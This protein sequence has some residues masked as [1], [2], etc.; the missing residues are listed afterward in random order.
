M[1]ADLFRLML[2]IAG[3]LLVLGIYFFGRNKGAKP[4][5]RIDHKAI[6]S[7]SEK[8]QERK[9][10]SLR[11]QA[12]PLESSSAVVEKKGATPAAHAPWPN[13]LLAHETTPAH[14]TAATQI[15][16]G[17]FH[18]TPIAS[19]TPEETAPDFIEEAPEEIEE[20][21]LAEAKSDQC[22]Q[23]QAQALRQDGPSSLSH[24][25]PHPIQSGS[26]SQDSWI[27]QAWGDAKGTL[28]G[29]VAKTTEPPVQAGAAIESEPESEPELLE[30]PTGRDHAAAAPVGPLPEDVPESIAEASLQPS[31]GQTDESQEPGFEPFYEPRY[32]A[33]YWPALS[34]EAEYPEAVP[35][36]GTQVGAIAELQLRFEPELPR[37][38]AVEIP[39][40]PLE[41]QPVSVQTPAQAIAKPEPALTPEPQA[42]TH[43]DLGTNTDTQPTEAEQ[44]E[45]ES[46]SL[47]DQGMAS[48]PEEVAGL[49][50]KPE[51]ESAAELEQAGSAGLGFEPE[52]QQ[53]PASTSVSHQQD[54]ELAS[55]TMPE[56]LAEFE[57]PEPEP[58]PAFKPMPQASRT[59]PLPTK[60]GRR[61]PRLGIDL[62]SAQLDGGRKEP[63]LAIPEPET[64]ATGRQEPWLQQAA[65]DTP[66][67][68]GRHLPLVDIEDE[69][70]PDQ[71][72][73]EELQD[74]ELPETAPLRAPQPLRQPLMSPLPKDIP[75]MLVQLSVVA[76]G[77]YIEGAEI[78]RATHE[79]GLVASRLRIFHRVDARTNEVI[80]S[81]ASM[82]EPG[83]FPMDDMSDFAT[84][85]MTLFLQL[86]CAI[87]SLAAYD[88]LLKTAERLGELLNAELQDQNHNL[89]RRQS[90]EYQRSE[91]QEHCRQV[92]LAK[93]RRDQRR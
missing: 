74:G 56:E 72:F 19:V 5:I 9:E 85:G 65:S 26:L 90:I 12:R 89:L 14:Q 93:R 54:I 52:L 25:M 44:P 31:Q 1:E 84:P 88:D 2:L 34:T 13:Q 47:L 70:D 15:P 43:S 71:L 66:S 3:A 22:G 4:S 23:Y 75:N 46:D 17:Q 28:S 21:A 69:L 62:A 20:L 67:L 18:S 39:T 36:L 63:R 32:E 42:A 24:P 37:P 53:P 58:E 33:S 55:E 80:F 86:P 49:E 59:T 11:Q 79:L 51:P 16:S 91:I 83:T 27:P 38:A 40:A 6:Q 76:R 77:A 48:E 87:D 64:L 35:G 68:D 82:I 29:P 8:V 57:E 10:P 7:T 41:P 60:P 78:L 73:D 30:N 92:Q 45:P 50:A 61:E 81:M